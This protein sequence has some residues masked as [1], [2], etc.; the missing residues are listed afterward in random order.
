ML[1]QSIMIGSLILSVSIVFFSLVLLAYMQETKRFLELEKKVSRLRTAD[2]LRSVMDLF[3]DSET[4]NL[5]EEAVNYYTVIGGEGKA[6]TVVNAVSERIGQVIKEIDMV[7]SKAKAVNWV[8]QE[9]YKF[10]LVGKFLIG[11]L[12]V[13]VLLSAFGFF[14]LPQQIRSFIYGG[15]IADVIAASV[16]LGY[17]LYKQREINQYITRML[18]NNLTEQ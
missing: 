16:F 8:N 1:S 5:L 11:S 10:K 13:M 7:L 4:S 17:I 6:E 3:T 15:L 18:K 9:I 14:L 12:I 2:F